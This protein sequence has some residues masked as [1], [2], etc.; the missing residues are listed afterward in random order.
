MP[1]LKCIKILFARNAPLKLNLDSKVP[2][3]LNDCFKKKRKDKNTI[4]TLLQLRLKLFFLSM[5]IK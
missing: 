4:K 3:N 1:C 5:V 2:I